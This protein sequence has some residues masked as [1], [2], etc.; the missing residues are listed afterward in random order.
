M[1]SHSVTVSTAENAPVIAAASNQSAIADE[2]K[3]ALR[4]GASLTSAQLTE[5]CPSAV[6]STAVSRVIYALRKAEVVIQDGVVLNGKEGRSAQ[7]VKRW[8]LAERTPIEHP[9]DGGGN[10][11][12]TEALGQPVCDGRFGPA[13]EPHP[14]EKAAMLNGT[15][16]EDFNLADAIAADIRA[17]GYS[18]TEDDEPRDVTRSMIVAELVDHIDTAVLEYADAALASDPVWNQLRSLQMGAVSAMRKAADREDGR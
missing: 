12:L 15:W 2:I 16:T 6:D 1:N 11:T 4:G 13:A 9:D 10:A 17:N 7:K 8:R 14:L 18:D 3:E 5:L